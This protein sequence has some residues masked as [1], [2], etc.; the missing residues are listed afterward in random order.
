MKPSSRAFTLIEL[1]VV[2]AII[3]ILAAIL[4]PVFAQAREAARK[5]TCL[6]NEKQLAMGLI[7]YVQ[8]YDGMMCPNETTDSQGLWAGWMDLTQP[9]VKNQDIWWCP[10]L[11]KP[12]HDPAWQGWFG[13]DEVYADWTIHVGINAW[14]ATGYFDFSAN[15]TVFRIRL[16]D[17]IDKPAQRAYL[18][19]TL[20]VPAW[21]YSRDTYRSI[22][23]GAWSFFNAYSWSID[24]NVSPGN[25]WNAI[26]PRHPLAKQVNGV[27]VPGAGGGYNTV[28][29]DG[30]AK[31]TPYGSEQSINGQGG[32]D[33][34]YWGP[35]WANN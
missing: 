19:D 1:L 33:I 22:G 35:W 12:T 31:Y 25:D 29:V 27:P 15:P 30:H 23:S 34:D 21:G 10:D 4:F 8:D 24:P 13:G 3:A 16:M 32:Y 11:P 28:F 6:S 14:G 26:D 20:S 9:Y 18:C 7:M 2:I 17:A 5:T